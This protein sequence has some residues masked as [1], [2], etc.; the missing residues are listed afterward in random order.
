MAVPRKYESIRFLGVKGLRRFLKKAAEL[1]GLSLTMWIREVLHR[2][3]C[4]IHDQ[5][6]LTYKAPALHPKPPPPLLKR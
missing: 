4:R 6:G 1:Q 2:E 5:H 3:A